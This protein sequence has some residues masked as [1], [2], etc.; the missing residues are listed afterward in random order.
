[1]GQHPVVLTAMHDAIDC[2]GAGAGGTRNV[3]G[4]S[5]YHVMLERE[6]ADLHDKEAAL[7]FTSG[8]VAN[9]SA[10]GTLGSQIPGCL[11]FSDAHNHASMI[12]ESAIVLPKSAS[13]GTTMQG[14]SSVSW[15]RRILDARSSSALNRFSSMDGDI[16]PISELCYVMSQ[17]V[18][19]R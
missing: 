1:M 16:A 15:R 2:A 8:Y 3:S 5:H 9:E 19:V 7:L 14:I 18:T 13:L 10:I 17:N 11:I 4:T 12:K 6:I